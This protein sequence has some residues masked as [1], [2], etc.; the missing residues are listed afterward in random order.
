MPQPI[1]PKKQVSS[2][3][4]LR[5]M[6]TGTLMPDENIGSMDTEPPATLFD[7]AVQRTPHNPADYTPEERAQYANLLGRNVPVSQG[8]FYRTDVDADYYN[9]GPG[10]GNRG[11]KNMGIQDSLYKA[12][13]FDNYEQQQRREMIDQLMGKMEKLFAPYGGKV[14]LE[15]KR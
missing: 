14:Q 2:S 10:R 13:L 12:Q 7:A 15:R 6:L 8:G 5:Q 3:Q 11:F 9:K 1:R 4:R